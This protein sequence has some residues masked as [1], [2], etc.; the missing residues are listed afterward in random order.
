MQQYFARLR[1]HRDAL[2]VA[3]VRCFLDA[4]HASSGCELSKR[5]ESEL[6][7][8]SGVSDCMPRA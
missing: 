1:P 4:A 7:E 5:H 8:A 6:L 2:M 3:Y